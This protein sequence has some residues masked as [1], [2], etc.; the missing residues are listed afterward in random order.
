MRGWQVV[1]VRRQAAEQVIAVRREVAEKSGEMFRS[2]T[3]DFEARSVTAHQ[4]TACLVI[5]LGSSCAN[6]V[7]NLT[8]HG[9]SCCCTFCEAGSACPSA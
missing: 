4:G 1:E 6:E 2:M 5:D 3:R 8:R 9:L 7:Y